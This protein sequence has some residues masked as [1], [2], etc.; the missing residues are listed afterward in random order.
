[1]TLKLSAY[2]PHFRQSGFYRLG[3]LC[4]LLLMLV[5]CSGKTKETPIQQIVINE[6]SVNANPEIETQLARL[7]TAIRLTQQQR[8]QESLDLLQTLQTSLLPIN[9]HWQ[10]LQVA[11]ISSLALDDGWLALRLIDRFIQQLPNLN[12]QQ[13]YLFFGYKADAFMLTGFYSNALQQ[14][15]NQALITQDKNQQQVAYQALWL[16]LLK[17]NGE[18]LRDLQEKENQPLLL[19]WLELALVRQMI[20]EQP[21]LFISRLKAWHKTW[22]YHPAQTFM[23]EEIELLTKLSQQQVQHL[24]VFLPE[25]GA[26]AD[27]ANALRDALIARQLDALNKGYPAP[28]ITFYNAESAL[29]DDLYNQAKKDGV[30]VVIGPLAK[31]Q[32][33]LLER[34][35]NLPLPTL[36]LN[37][38]NDEK[39]RNKSLYQ[40]GLSAENEAEQIALKAWQ[41]GFRRALVLTPESN[42]G[43]R[44]EQS[45]IDTWQKL[46]GEITHSRQYGKTL[47]L[48]KSL[49]E[50]LEVQLSEQRHR[51]IINLLGKR[52][53]FSPRPREDSDFLFIHATSA[54]ARQIKPALSFLRASNLPVLATSSVYSGASDPSRDKDMDGIIFCDI[55]W[56]LEE[57]N[58]LEQTVRQAWPDKMVNYGRLYAMGADAYLLAQRLPLL[59]A[60]PEIR[61][62]GATGRL[63]QTNRRIKRELQWAQ[64]NKGKVESLTAD[65]FDKQQLV[66]QITSD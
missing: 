12:Q 64:F 25:G 18:T 2:P 20:T 28:K 10:A 34:R 41:N 54:D 55:P 43:T 32:V 42:W 14:R 39:F 44:I 53:H 63:S 30:E 36:A 4:L 27:S 29:L 24:G 9:H 49:R 56:Y 40:F 6:R 48:D 15:H 58:T 35:S 65:A 66:D 50:L 57:G 47:T 23:P 13:Q 11:A 8:Y 37:Y 62:D 21:E 60:L 7:E 3:V 31:A 16:N 61:I 59:N 38:G 22:P 17:M 1:M 5:G 51:R 33:D 45:F 52:P 19:G 46:G 26:M